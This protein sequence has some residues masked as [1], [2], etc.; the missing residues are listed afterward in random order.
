MSG[1]LSPYR[2]AR[3]AR[4]SGIARKQRG[5]ANRGLIETIHTKILQMQNGA[6]CYEAHGA[7]IKEDKETVEKSKAGGGPQTDSTPKAE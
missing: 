2:N 7:N 1:F 6:S 5:W 4:S 3:K